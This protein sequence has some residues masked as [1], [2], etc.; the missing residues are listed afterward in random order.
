M[1][2]KLPT[3]G[4][5]AAF[6]ATDFH[7]LG[8][9]PRTLKVGQAPECHN[10]WLRQ[11]GYQSATVITAWNPFSKARSERTNS[12]RQ[13][14]LL[15][16]IVDAGL[17]WVDAKGQDPTGDWPPEKSLC[18]FD[19]SRAHANTWLVKFRQYA[20]VEAREGKACELVWHPEIPDSLAFDRRGS[21]A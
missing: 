7:V 4:L 17:S 6:K 1:I 10:E 9:Q 21:T 15:K 2:L 19:A 16:L 8:S 5:V 13:R 12:R 14:Q 11:L 3:E 18:V 20:A